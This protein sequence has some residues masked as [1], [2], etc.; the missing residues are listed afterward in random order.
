MLITPVFCGTFYFN[1]EIIFLNLF[2][3][4]KMCPNQVSLSLFKI[5]IG[6]IYKN[7]YMCECMFQSIKEVW[8]FNWFRK[9]GFCTVGGVIV[10][11]DYLSLW[12]KESPFSQLK[13]Y[14]YP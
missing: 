4:N 5:Y 7:K 12:S 11:C 13:S 3:V 10:F 1:T 6:E 2:I 8:C 9:H 14:P